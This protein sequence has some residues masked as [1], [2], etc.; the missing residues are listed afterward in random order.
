MSDWISGTDTVTALAL[1]T[2]L[3]AVDT[4][5]D[6]DNAAWDLDCFRTALRIARAT[7]DPSDLE[8]AQLA[9]RALRP[10]SRARLL[11][12][13]TILATQT[14]QAVSPAQPTERRAGG[15]AAFVASLLARPAT[16]ESGAIAKSR[17][18]REVVGKG[19]GSF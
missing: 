6:I 4:M 10:D 16:A 19:G 2:L 5:S 7:E 8:R 17:L 3:R 13:V 18:M 11:K 9:Y 1:D 12:H 14:N 15:V